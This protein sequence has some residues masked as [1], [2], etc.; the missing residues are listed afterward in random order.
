MR[1][2]L[3]CTDPSNV[4]STSIDYSL[5]W[6]QLRDWRILELVCHCNPSRQEVWYAYFYYW[7]DLRLM[8]A[9]FLFHY[10]TMYRPLYCWWWSRSNRLLK[11]FGNAFTKHYI[12]ASTLAF[13]VQSFLLDDSFSF[14][15]GSGKVCSKLHSWPVLAKAWRFITLLFSWVNLHPHFFPLILCF[16]VLKRGFGHFSDPSSLFHLSPT[17]SYLVLAALQITLFNE[18]GGFLYIVLAT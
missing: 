18:T 10:S 12:A 14:H 1:G 5:V 4:H 16:W 13:V 8:L 7:N 17:T 6:W 15:S 11:E 9:P 2:G 3:E